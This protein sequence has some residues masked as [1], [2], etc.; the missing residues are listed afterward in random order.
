MTSPVAVFEPGRRPGGHPRAAAPAPRD[1][2][3]SL[4]ASSGCAPATSAPPRPLSQP[5]AVG[6]IR[7]A[8]L[9]EQGAQAEATTTNLSLLGGGVVRYFV[10]DNV[11]VGLHVGIFLRDLSSKVG[12]AKTSTREVGGLG[13]LSAAYYAHLTG[14]M[15]AAPLVGVGGFTCGLSFIF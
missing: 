8:P 13:T 9:A 5:R 10:A 7:F 1:A 12:D 14:G 4:A 6:A 2:P 3:R 15:F 11:M